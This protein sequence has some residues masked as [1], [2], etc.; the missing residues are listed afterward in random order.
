MLEAAAKALALSFIIVVSLGILMGP[1]IAPEE[2]TLPLQA[3]GIA[4]CFLRGAI[5]PR[6]WPAKPYLLVEF[7][8]ALASA[9][10]FIATNGKLPVLS[11]QARTNDSLV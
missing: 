5:V 10:H 7:S 3:A 6:I 2:Y 11:I 4:A 9:V 8:M 1:I